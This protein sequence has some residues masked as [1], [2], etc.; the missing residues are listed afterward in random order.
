MDCHRS[1]DRPAYVRTLRTTKKGVSYFRLLEEGRGGSLVE[2]NMGCQNAKLEWNITPQLISWK[3]AQPFEHTARHNDSH[4]HWG[5][6]Y[7]LRCGSTAN[8]KGKRLI[9]GQSNLVTVVNRGNTTI[10]Q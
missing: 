5:L 9:R 10:L 1:K 8:K 7:L 4:N 6:N 3:E 2:A